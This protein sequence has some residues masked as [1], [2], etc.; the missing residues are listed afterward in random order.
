MLVCVKRDVVH[1]STSQLT[2]VNT[3]ITHRTSMDVDLRDLTHK[4]TSEDNR[5]TAGKCGVIEAVVSAMKTHTDNAN[6]CW[7]GCCAHSNITLNGKCY[8]THRT[9]MSVDLRDSTHKHTHQRTT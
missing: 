6:V 1:S 3:I 9:S 5:V 4:Y 7:N 2:M 8:Q